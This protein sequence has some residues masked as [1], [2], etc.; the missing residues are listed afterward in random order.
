MNA[1]SLDFGFMY[2]PKKM[3]SMHELRSTPS[4]EIQFRQNVLRREIAIE[5]QVYIQ[6]WRAPPKDG[7]QVRKF[8][9]YNR[10]ET[11]QF[12]VPFS[13]LDKIYELNAENNK[14]VLLISLETPPRFFRKVPE[15]D[16]HEEN[17]RFWSQND[18]WYR[19]TDIVY[20]AKTIKSS[21]L[22]LK[23]TKPVIDIGRWTTY[24]FVLDMAKNNQNRFK[25]MCQ[26]FKDHNIEVVPF[27]GFNIINDREPAVWDYID[28]PIVQQSKTNS[29][30]DDLIEDAVSLPFPVR[31]QLE[32]CISQG[33]LNEHNLSQEFVI[34]LMATDVVRAQDLLEYVANQKKRVWDPM[35]I[36]NMNVIRGSASRP[37]IPSYCAYTRSATVTPSTIYY[38]TP[39]IETSNRVIRQYAAVHGDR[40]L[41]VRF[42]DEKFEGRINPTDKD[43]SDEIFTRIKRVMINGITIG[44]RHYEFLAFGNSQFR[45]HGAYF[46]APT[47]HLATEDIRRWMGMFKEIK[48]VAKHAARLGQCFSTTRAISGTKVVIEEIDDIWRN[49]KNFSDG[50]GKISK[51]L[52][53]ITASEL[54]ITHSPSG[55]P[56]VYQFRLGGCKGVLA[57]SPDAKKREI[58]IRESQYKFPAV[59]EGLEIIRWSQFASANLNRQL[60]LVL[61]ALGVPDEIFINKLKLQLVNLEQAMNDTRMSLSLLQKDVDANQ[62][63]LVLAGMV[64]DGFQNA[65]EPFMMSLLQLWRAWSIKYLKEKARIMIGDGALLLG[66][67]DETSALKGHFDDVVQPSHND[68]VEEKTKMLPEVFVQIATTPDEKPRVILGPML[69]ARNPSLHPGDIRV[70]CGVDVPEL[71]HLRDVVVLPQTGDRDLAG[72]CSGGD[73]DGDDYLVIWDTDLLPH[74]WNHEPMDYSP[75][76]PVKV[77]RE[78]TV[79]DITSF[80]VTYMKNDMLPRIAHAHV[81]FAD[82]MDAGVK[83][84]KCLHLAALHSMAVDYVKTG[85]P[86]RMPRELAPRKWPHFME[87]NHKPKEAIYVS[88]K[89]LGKLYDQVERVDFVPAFSIP[90]D[91]RILR[92]YKFHDRTLRD[93]ATLKLE[94]DAAMRRIMAQHDI[95][96]EFEVWSTFVLH[97]SNQSKDYKFHEEIGQLSSALKDQYRTSCYRLVGSKSFEFMGPFVAA[98]YRITQLEMEE[99]IKECRQV[100]MV[101]GKEERVRRME[102]ETMPLM[103]FPWLFPDVLGK[104][105]NGNYSLGSEGIDV[106]TAVQRATKLTPPKKLKAEYETSNGGDTLET[107][108][109]VTHRGEV[110][111]LFDK[112]IDIDDNQQDGHSENGLKSAV[113]KS[114][115]EKPLSEVSVISP[116]DLLSGDSAWNLLTPR[117]DKPLEDGSSGI[118]SGNLAG[119]NQ[120]EDGSLGMSSENLADVS[121]NDEDVWSSAD[122]GSGELIH[123]YQGSKIGRSAQTTANDNLLLDLRGELEESARGEKDSSSSDKDLAEV[124]GSENTEEEETLAQA[125]NEAANKIYGLEAANLIEQAA[126]P[127]GSPNLPSHPLAE[128][129]SLDHDQEQNEIIAS[130][131][132]DARNSP[133]AATASSQRSYMS[134][135]SVL[136]YQAERSKADGKQRDGKQPF[137]L[138]DEDEDNG[139]EEVIIQMDV[140]PSALDQLAD[141]DLE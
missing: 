74:E 9:R 20:N 30:L 139:A 23:K 88:H 57:I 64:V 132:G 118:S 33:C 134:A 39:T 54:G 4:T 55:P 94:Y 83:D 17:A 108:D 91:E 93:A 52:A 77:D 43:T 76:D 19:Q 127:R 81:A 44:D 92:A 114:S 115:S 26:A 31:Y 131:T 29:A 96:T 61:S 86:A 3:M 25:L 14:I 68:S 140:K 104:I 5:M 69:L 98:M 35:D 117:E 8:G 12:R 28:K 22:T 97:H 128:S 1:T 24:R 129:Y 53:Q 42:T 100:T 79:D 112:L 133:N 122:S 37:R 125:H 56:S 51:L 101:G 136:S 63:T 78:V 2:D 6:D 99:A 75:P 60:I 59:H 89:V 41:R 119:N 84:E 95:K 137:E 107:A 73:L 111:E 38:N 40:F 7:V 45:E 27:P 120:I 124:M 46:F 49:G 48:I 103:S 123:V 21:S 36:F 10:I 50:V 72:M 141:L 110:L 102:P 11:Y 135:L 85:V 66:C 113:V 82:F 121:G 71:H 47:T 116:D 32:V 15:I 70:V 105:A 58:H 65:R 18:A 126:C 16:T 90:F 109:G 130:L 87:K 34:Q 67:V 62:M 80:F 106:T 138:G 13:Q